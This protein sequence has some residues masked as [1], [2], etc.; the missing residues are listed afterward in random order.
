MVCYLTRLVRPGQVCCSPS[1]ALLYAVC[2]AC[3]QRATYREKSL[4]YERVSRELTRVETR[5]VRAA[6][7][8]VVASGATGCSLEEV[9]S[10]AIRTNGLYADILALASGDG[11][12]L[13][14]VELAVGGDN[15]TTVNLSG[16][17]DLVASAGGPPG[18]LVRRGAGR[19][20]LRIMGEGARDVTVELV[21][22]PED[23]GASGVA[24]MPEPFMMSLDSD[25][26][27]GI[28]RGSPV[29][30]SWEPPVAGGSVTWS[31]EG[32]CIWSESG[33]TPDDG[34]LTLAATSFR[35][36]GT[37]VGQECDVSVTLERANSGSVD[38]ILVPGSKFIAAQRRGV[39]F[40]STPGPDEGGAAP[41]PAPDAGS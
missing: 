1:V 33:Q 25:D 14:R 26:T 8:T 27:A 22:G 38:S 5:F 32:R 35:V 31:V 15:G 21:R 20:E 34:S 41:V 40:V 19:Y 17:D 2:V 16:D 29:T 24:S 23:D 36:R 12:T 13:V 6:L 30:V 39:S 7:A 18:S 37:R 3:L 28:D 11:E 4:A 10:D 9:N